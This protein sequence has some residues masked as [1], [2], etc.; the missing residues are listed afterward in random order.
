MESDSSNDVPILTPPAEA[1]AARSRPFDDNVASSARKRRRTSTSGSPAIQNPSSAPEYALAIISALDGQT[2]EPR[3][4]KAL[5]HD[6]CIS[7]GDATTVSLQGQSIR[8]TRNSRER[9]RSEHHAP[10]SPESAAEKYRVEEI[11]ESVENVAVPNTTLEKPE[12]ESLEQASGTTEREEDALSMLCDPAIGIPYAKSGD[13]PG[14]ALYRI[15]AY[16]SN[17]EVIG[18]E[19]LDNLSLWIKECTL[20]VNTATEEAINQH[21]RDNYAL[22]RLLP[23]IPVAVADR[24]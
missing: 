1:F 16:L 7:D 17:E 11:R 15:L 12:A 2:D 24:L 18:A 22:W 10:E 3:P 4:S 14:E 9:D 20:F 13:E 5:Q 19:V 23:E 8:A 6:Q 21:Y